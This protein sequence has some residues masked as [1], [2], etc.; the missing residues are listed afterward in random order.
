MD[1]PSAL[2]QGAAF[3]VGIIDGFNCAFD[4]VDRP[5]GQLE[6]KAVV[7]GVQ[8]L[9]SVERFG[10]TA[11]P[12]ADLAIR[13]V[14]V[15][16]RSL[17]DRLAEARGQRLVVGAVCGRGDLKLAEQGRIAFGELDDH[18]HEVP[19]RLVFEMGA[20][21]RERAGA[22]RFEALIDCVRGERGR[23]HVLAEAIIVECRTVTLAVD[24]LARAE[25]IDAIIFRSGD[26]R[27]NAPG[28]DRQDIDAPLSMV[29]LA[30]GETRA[31]EPLQSRDVEA[32]EV[33]SRHAAARVF[34]RSPSCAGRAAD[35]R[36]A[37]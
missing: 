5:L 8:R 31:R 37:S 7:P 23:H 12:A 22:C 33:F 3:A 24:R 32:W 6:D 18:R 30:A 2:E 16:R 17:V 28:L 4:P 21:A 14:A 36:T 13:D 20:D 35:R 25:E 34:R 1:V 15:R 9:E 27:Q 29:G 10:D 11:G 19:L 26:P